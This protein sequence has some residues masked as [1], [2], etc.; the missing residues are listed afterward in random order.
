LGLSAQYRLILL[1]AEVGF[2]RCCGGDAGLAAL[3]G[4]VTVKDD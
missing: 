1:V 4:S 3:A 2:T